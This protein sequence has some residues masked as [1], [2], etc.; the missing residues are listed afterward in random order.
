MS[1]VINTN[2]AS[3]VAQ[4]AQAKTSSAMDTAMER[5]STG[6]RI[7]TAADDAAG[8]AISNRM[9]AQIAGLAMAMKNAGDAQSLIDTTE[10]AHD[11][12]TNILQRMREL[13]V[14]SANDTNVASDRAN[15]QAE[16]DQLLA[17]IDRISTQTTWNGM[18]LMNGTFTS[19][20]FQIGA[21]AGQDVT[22]NVSN[23]AS[24]SIGN[25]AYEAVGNL[26]VD[27]SGSSVGAFTQDTYTVSGPKGNATVAALTGDTAKEFAAA[28]NAKSH[29]TG[30]SATAVTHALISGSAV[31]G[32]AG[33][34]NVTN[35]VSVDLEINDV[36]ITSA[37]ITSSDLRSLRDA[38]N[39]ISAQTGVTAKMGSS[40]SDIILTDI[41][42]DDIKI[43]AF[44]ATGTDTIL[45][46][47]ALKTDAST[48]AGAEEATATDKF[49]YVTT[50]IDGGNATANMDQVT[51]GGSTNLKASGA[52][53][54]TGGAAW[55]GDDET[56]ASHIKAA[57][58]SGSLSA[59]STASIRTA[60]LAET[61]ITSIDGAIDMISSRRA[62]LG[63]ISNRLD[64]TINNLSNIKVNVESSQ[65]RIQ[66]ADFAAETSNL[67]KTQILSQAATAMLAQANASK[68]SVLSL[69]QG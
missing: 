20:Q 12:I 18:S 44:D 17:E 62:D 28:V 49:G 39:A 42:G 54:V 46:V 69:L 41:D 24:N 33:T 32:T 13:A 55:A 57:S 45:G 30:V 31:T 65:S 66:D 51:I 60:A 52:F 19:K 22:V 23:T 34:E 48:Y 50:L 29:L 37:S 43:D 25:Y 27:D 61:A 7:N 9:D 1:M 21:E 53:T 5:L 3:L 59:V 16:M 35:T 63:A 58:V 26:Q 38:I 68:Q 2:T 10:G 64:H 47:A 40:N 15:L 11:E 56:D 67:T 4:A 14:Q 36:A 6:K 8:L